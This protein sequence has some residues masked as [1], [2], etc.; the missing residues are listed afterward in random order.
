MSQEVVFE[1][2][3][4]IAWITLNRPAARNALTMAMCV[5]LAQIIAALRTDADS[6]VVVLRASGSDFTVGAD[7]KDM[8]T[9]LS[10]SPTQRA[11]DISAT[12]RDISWPIFLGLDRLRQPII[13]SV[14]GHVIGAGAQLLLSADLVVASETAKLLI[15]QVRLAHPVDHGESYSLPRKIGMARTMQLLLMAEPLPA[16][17]AERF[18][19]VNWVVAD[20][21]LEQKTAEVVQRIA[22]AAPVA[23]AETKALVRGSQRRTIEEQF[24]AEADALAVCAATEDFPEAIQAF[25]QKRTPQFHGR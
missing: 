22:S 3:D 9:S 18:G 11:K 17:E 12:A 25:V 24:A 5:E 13:A 20:A 15:P 8:A 14:R 19:L 6:R 2:V 10:A 16:G 4:G 21:A 23:I 1:K 7:L